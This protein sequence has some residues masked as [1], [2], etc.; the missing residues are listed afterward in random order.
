[1]VDETEINVSVVGGSR[2]AT[3]SGAQFVVLLVNG[4]VALV[5]HCLLISFVIFLYMF[6][7]LFSIF[8]FRFAY[9]PLYIFMMFGAFGF[10][11]KL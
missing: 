11:C 7:L 9:S 1:M 8:A 6:F 3:A 10:D 5:W 2:G 4:F